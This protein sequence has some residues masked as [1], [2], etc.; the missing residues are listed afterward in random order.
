MQSELVRELIWHLD[1]LEAE[2]LQ[3]SELARG[4]ASEQ[5]RPTKPADVQSERLEAQLAAGQIPETNEVQSPEPSL[6]GRQDHSLPPIR[7]ILSQPFQIDRL[8]LLAHI[9]DLGRATGINVQP[10]LLRAQSGPLTGYTGDRSERQSYITWLR[11]KAAEWLEHIGSASSTDPPQATDQA[12]NPH[13]QVGTRP[14]API[15]AILTAQPWLTRRDIVELYK[16]KGASEDAVDSF[17]RR[18][19]KANTG[20]RILNPDRKA[21]RRAKYVYLN[22]MVIPECNRKWGDV[23]SP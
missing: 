17:L 3:E 5:E 21:N 8:P 12:P 2:I 16:G 10:D 13:R 11:A 20:C 19:A 18:L 7:E 4:T 14:I 23:T 15:S 22:A 6:H 1:L 9:Q